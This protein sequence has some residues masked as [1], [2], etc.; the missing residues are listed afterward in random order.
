MT[1]ADTPRVVTWMEIA[2]LTKLVANQLLNQDIKIDCVAGLARGGLIP[3]VQISHML[4]VPMVSINLSLRDNR[5][6]TNL[7]DSNTLILLAKYKHV[8]VIDDITD[9]GKTMHAVDVILS[10][11]TYG[12]DTITYC[13]LFHK[14]SS[15]F[16]PKVIGETISEARNNQWIIFPWES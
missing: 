6:E 9:S 10:G 11:R 12:P 14:V 8:A 3:A 16:C 7:Y 5:V 2:E 15:I 1:Q 13:S 4:D